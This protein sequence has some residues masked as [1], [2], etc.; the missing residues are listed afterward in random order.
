MNKDIH[1][2]DHWKKWLYRDSVSTGVLSGIHMSSGR[3]K[4]FNKK[5]FVIARWL[6]LDTINR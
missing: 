3:P 5:L 2:R 4:F 1:K 6:P